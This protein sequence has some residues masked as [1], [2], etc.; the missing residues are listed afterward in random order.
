[1][2]EDAVGLWE[3]ANAALSGHSPETDRLFMRQ[4]LEA[5]RVTLEIATFVDA[6]PE[7]IVQAMR[8]AIP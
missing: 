6:V 3:H 5:C 7:R 1:M 8:E 2:Y 4:R